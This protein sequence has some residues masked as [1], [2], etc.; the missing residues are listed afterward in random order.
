MD[1]ALG[2]DSVTALQT[3]RRALLQGAMLALLLWTAGCAQFGAFSDSLFM[4]SPEQE[5]QFGQ[6]TAAEVDK[7]TKPLTD[8]MV[9]DYVQTVGQRLWKFA[10]KG[11][12][13]PHFFVIQDKELN[14]FAIPGG[15]IYIQSGLINAAEDEAEMAAVV[16]HEMGHVYYRHGA[17]QVS[18]ATS[19]SV[20]EQILLGTEGGQ[21]AQLVSG[22]LGQGVMFNYSRDAEREADAVAVQTL[23]RA[24]Y[25]PKAM[26]TFFQKL[27]KTYGESK[28]PVSTFF[29]T[30]PPTSERIRNVNMQVGQ[31]PKHEGERPVTE[32]RRVQGRLKNL[33]IQ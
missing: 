33:G 9:A 14:A 8:P 3:S 22:L 7:Q 10:P 27:L 23:Y 29:A 13:Q 12:I 30:H 5:V 6:K 11:D 17:R 28:G 4:M 20:V 2:G 16:A 32:L 26:G 19:L 1:T 24:G 21:A 31:L 25:D 18:R 15:N